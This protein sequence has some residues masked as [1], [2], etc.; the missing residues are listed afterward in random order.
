[1]AGGVSRYKRVTV[2][3]DESSLHCVPQLRFLVG[4]VFRSA[5][6]LELERPRV[7]KKDNLRARRSLEVGAYDLAVRLAEDGSP[8]LLE[9]F[10]HRGELALAR[11]REGAKRERESRSFSAHFLVR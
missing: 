9:A 5:S 7:A 3:L 11:G 4:N 2:C 8:V 6:D 10:F 1:M